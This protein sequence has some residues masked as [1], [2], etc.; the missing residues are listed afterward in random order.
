MTFPKVQTSDPFQFPPPPFYGKGYQFSGFPPQSNVGS[1][2]P[3]Q[4]SNTS[5]FYE[6]THAQVPR[7]PQ[8]SDDDPPPKGDVTYRE[9]R[10]EVQCLMNDQEI[11][12]T[13]IIHSNRRSLRGTARTM[14]IPLG[15]KSKSKGNSG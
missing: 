5:H 7:I 12:E 6:V 3:N 10:Y 15:G 1:F 14:L 2:R 13:T 4:E 9:W 8:F 11:N